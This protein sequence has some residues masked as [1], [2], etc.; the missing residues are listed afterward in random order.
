MAGE[1]HGAGAVT[2]H[3]VVAKAGPVSAACGGAGAV[4]FIFTKRHKSA[5]DYVHMQDK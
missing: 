2:N 3:F 4:I 5:L 1:I